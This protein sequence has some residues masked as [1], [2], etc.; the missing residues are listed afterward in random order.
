LDTPDSWLLL[1]L[2]LSEAAFVKGIQPVTCNLILCF[3]AIFSAFQDRR[4]TMNRDNSRPVIREICMSRWKAYQILVF[5]LPLPFGGVA[6][7]AWPLY[8]TAAL[9]LLLAEL[10]YLLKVTA[11]AQLPT[12][13]FPE[14]FVRARLLLLV[15]ALVQLWVFAQWLGTSLSPYDTWVS[16]LKGI[17]LT[18]F[19]A[20]TLLMLNSRE[21]VKRILWVAVLAAAFQALYGAVMVLTGWEYGFFT[22]KVFYRTTAT[23]TFVNRN[24]L[25]GYLE[26]TLAL[27]IGF[28][29]AQSTRYYGSARQRLRQLIAMLL[30]DKVVL[31]LLLAVMVIAL[32]LTRSRMGNTAFFAS[33]M[34]A[35]GLALL[36]M[37]HK[38]RSTTILL[39]SL[40]VIDIAIVG[41]FFGVDKVAERLQKTSIQTESRPQVSRDTFIMW[42]QYPVTGTGA[43]TF[44]QIYPT[45]KSEDVRNPQ[46]YNNAHNDLVQFLAEFGAPAYL[47]LAGCVGWCLWNAVVAMRKRNSEL[48]KGMGFAALMGISAIGIHSAVDFNLQI[49][50]NAFMF[51]LLMAMAFIARWAPHKTRPL[52]DITEH[53]HHHSEAHNQ[54]GEAL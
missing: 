32:V 1:L 27:G 51:M 30:S 40:L 26:I 47:M 2:Q 25:A 28:L 12:I 46:I 18:A 19:F 31:R 38:T 42:E 37:R 48:Y 13:P 6:D 21:R 53:K 29:L 41:T 15:L 20:L 34:L 49:P 8:C 36:L 45:F 5:V 33:L 44:T 22:E 11:V 23:G 9:V 4:L 52:P 3:Q 50:S 24:S 39:S 54:Q 43:G 35:G 17:G 10:N 14:A 7:W 16:L